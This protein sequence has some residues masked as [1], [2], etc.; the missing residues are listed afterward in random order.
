ML[1]VER[2]D[3]LHDTEHAFV[4]LY[5]ES[6]SAF[7]LDSSRIDERARFSFMGDAGGPLGASITYDVHRA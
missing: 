2:L 7:W 3:T 5:G 6:E 4:A 1:R